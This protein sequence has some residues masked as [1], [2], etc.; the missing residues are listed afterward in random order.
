[1]VFAAVREHNQGLILNLDV[2][3]EPN[4]DFDSEIDARLWHIARLYPKGTNEL[5]HPVQADPI[6]V[7]A[8]IRPAK[9][10]LFNSNPDRKNWR[11]NNQLEKYQWNG[12]TDLP[13]SENTN[14]LFLDHQGYSL[15]AAPRLIKGLV[16]MKGCID[17]WG[18]K[19]NSSPK[20]FYRD[21]NYWNAADNR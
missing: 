12:I 10:K 21:T 4:A 17:N 11:D 7:Q 6:Q 16:A 8:F 19:F 13:P 9:F 18:R 20:V 14:G 2:G 1:M 15:F 3:D 5:L